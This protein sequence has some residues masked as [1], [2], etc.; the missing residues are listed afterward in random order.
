MDQ[1]FIKR[2]GG[3][4]SDVKRLSQNVSG[5]ES[6]VKNVIRVV[7]DVG[8]SVR[9]LTSKISDSHKTD[10][11]AIAGVA[12]VLV[13][14]MTSIGYMALEPYKQITE[15]NAE[16][17]KEHKREMLEWRLKHM[18]EIHEIELETI[19]KLNL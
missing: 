11:Q 12:G 18:R 3:L 19:K 15:R 17:I 1:D 13:A 16:E 5:L 8:D 9:F 2:V 4:E 7:N 6:D 14:I 10:W